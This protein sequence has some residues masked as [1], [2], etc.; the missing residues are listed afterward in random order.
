MPTSIEQSAPVEL[1]HA[2]LNPRGTIIGSP[3]DWRDQ[4]LYFLLPDRFSDGGESQRPLFDRANPQQF[5]T[6]NKR[7]WMEAGKKFQGGTLKGV[8]SKLDYLKDLGVTALWVG[9]IWRQRPDLET[10]HGYGIQNFLDLDPR[11]GTRQDL[12]DLVD[13][14]HARGMYVL[15]DIIYNH[16]GNNWF[17]DANGTARDTV[18][19]RFQPPYPVHGWRSGTGQSIANIGTLDDGVWPKEFQ[20]FDWYTRAGQIGKFDPEPWEDPLHPDNEFRRGDFFDLKD[21]NLNRNDALSAVIRVYQYWIGLSDC[22]GFR[23]DT[24][25]HTPRDGTR[26]FCGA[27][28]EYAEAIGKE[29]FWLLGEV[30]GGAEMARNY[31]EVFGRNIDAVLDIG[32]PASQLA[33]MVK[34]LIAARAFF[35]LFLG[36]DSL[37]SHRETGRYHVSILDDHDM[38]GRGKHRFGALNTIQNRTHQVAH[39][40]GTQ[41]TTLGIPC[42]YYGT[43]QAFDG[44]ESRHDFSIEPHLSFEDRYIRESM[45]GGTFGAFETAGCHFFDSNHPTYLRIAAIA[46][47]RNQQNKVGLALRRGR[48]YLRETSFLDQPFA[49]PRPGELV[50]WSRIQFDREVLV[51]LNSHGTENRGADVTVDATLHPAGSIMT[52]LYNGSWSDAELRQPPQNQTVQVQQ[53]NGRATVRIDL[54]PAGMV[55]LT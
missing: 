16:S 30:T 13:A 29:Y 51:A 11:F 6:A 28:H 49:D 4:V 37:G 21:I 53:R 33:G 8:T 43:E 7:A 9:P 5:K 19:Y 35:D 22:D 25:K 32:G 31:L 17:Y 26:N 50:A 15:L 20:N 42:I 54:P 14:A 27:I 36:H 24:V 41:L 38:V 44:S 2:N 46:R 45:F 52:F 40:V 55:I 18:P 1:K 10:Y 39:A 48:Q 12:R 34:G 3:I 23:I 47:V